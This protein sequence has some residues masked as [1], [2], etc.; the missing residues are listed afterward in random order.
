MELMAPM[1]TPERKVT[2]LASFSHFITHGF[3]T[4]FPAVMV[5]IA[6]ENSMSF[7]AIG[8]IANIGYFLYGLGAFPAGWLAD[9]YGSKRVLT[10][11]VIGM[12]AASMLVGASVG[13]LTFGLSYALLGMFASIHH[14]A[15]LSLIA[16]RVTANKGKALG[17]HGVMGNVGLFLTPLFAASCILLFD[18]WRTAYFLY[19]VIGVVFSVMLYTARIP[20]EADLS[21]AE[22]AGCCGASARKKRADARAAGAESGSGEPAMSYLP[23]ALLLLFLG[24]ILSGYVY[25]GSLT[26]FP[27]LLRQEVH[28]I[29][30]H[31][32]PVVM[33]GYLTTAI[34]SFGLIGAWFGGWINDKVRHPE[35]V[36]AIIFVC[37]APLLYLVSSYSDTRLI[38]VGCLFSLIYYAWQPAQNYLIARYTKKASHGIGFGVNFFLIFGLGSIAT[39]TGGYVSDDYGVDVFYWIMSIVAA[40]AAVTGF[41]VYMV[42]RYRLRYCLRLEK[43][44]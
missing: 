19:G 31:D 4:L 21:F 16:R 8:I 29:T 26:F 7:L 35:F 34:L 27:A 14:P 22:I 5:V 2:W 30:N 39:A 18:S 42:R 44:E 28:F 43:G 36:P 10:V 11:G 9:R 24:S 32:E 1:M 37:I 25:R 17:I 12:S 33:A 38:V 13:P 23:V 41:A 6:G 20:E 15:G 40:V 3:M